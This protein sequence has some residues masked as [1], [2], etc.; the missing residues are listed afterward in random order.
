[1]IY[2][3]NG[4]CGHR[5]AETAKRWQHATKSRMQQVRESETV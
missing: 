1:M 2:L 3:F 5:F 4:F